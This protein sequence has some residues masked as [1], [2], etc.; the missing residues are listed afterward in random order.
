MAIKNALIQRNKIVL[1]EE[2]QRISNY[3]VKSHSTKLNLT[4]SV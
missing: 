1:N 2:A 4:M 3:V